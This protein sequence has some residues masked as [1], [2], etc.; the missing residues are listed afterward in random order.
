MHHL[1]VTPLLGDVW[2]GF[3]YCVD[4]KDANNS[5]LFASTDFEMQKS[6][7]YAAIFSL[8]PLSLLPLNHTGL[9]RSSFSG[10]K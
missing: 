7:F 5:N 2:I 8:K 6:Q 1:E 3:K 10:Y 9:G 4:R